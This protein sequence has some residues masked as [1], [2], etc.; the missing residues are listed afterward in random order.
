MP[1][2]GLASSA[3]D[4]G[5]PLASPLALPPETRSSAVPA[6]E[7]AHVYMATELPSGLWRPE[8]LL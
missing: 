5:V 1:G 6:P 7:G 8:I 2:M 3:P 4:K